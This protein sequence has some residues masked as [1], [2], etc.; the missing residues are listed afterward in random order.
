VNKL[1]LLPTA[2]ADY[3]EALAW[4]FERSEQ[5]AAAFETGVR[6]GLQRIADSP[7]ACPPYDERHRFYLLRRFPFSIVYRQERDSTIVVVAIA[8]SSRDA[9]F[10]QSR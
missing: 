2:E 3:L 10:W 1:V 7:D 4:Y 9:S 5:A 8:H 6:I